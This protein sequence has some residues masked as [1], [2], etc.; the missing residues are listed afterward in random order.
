MS[1]RRFPAGGETAVPVE[2][3]EGLFDD[4][5]D[6]DHVVSGATPR[7]PDR[8][9]AAASSERVVGWS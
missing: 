7:N 3:G 8:D 6:R 5:A 1:V 2:Q 4:P 9:A